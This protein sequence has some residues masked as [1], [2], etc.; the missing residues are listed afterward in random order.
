MKNCKRHSPLGEVMSDFDLQIALE[1]VKEH[2]RRT[3][4]TTG[5]VLAAHLRANGAEPSGDVWESAKLLLR[6]GRSFAEAA[7][8]AAVNFAEAEPDGEE[9]AGFEGRTTSI[10]V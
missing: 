5:T 10:G 8:P 9:A 6:A 7:H 4:L 2:F 1:P 3:K